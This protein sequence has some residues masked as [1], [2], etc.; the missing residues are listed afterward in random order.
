MGT[1]TITNET[2]GIN[3]SFIH[4]TI[5][6]NGDANLS[7]SNNINNL[8]GQIYITTGNGEYPIGNYNM[9]SLNLNDNKYSDYI[10]L[11]AVALKS[12]KVE[13]N[14]KYPIV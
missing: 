2:K 13:I 10:D 6:L 7:S 9:N 12:L 4:E 11:C 14:L 3:Y 1:L 5:R 8:N